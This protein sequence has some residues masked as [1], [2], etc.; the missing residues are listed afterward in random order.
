MHINTIMFTLIIHV[1]FCFVS[2]FAYEF[3]DSIGKDW[4]MNSTGE[5]GRWFNDTYIEKLGGNW[6]WRRQKYSVPGY[7]NG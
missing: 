3:K 7:I 6:D 5:L 1:V 4:S 2:I